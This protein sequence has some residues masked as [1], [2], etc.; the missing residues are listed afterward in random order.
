MFNRNYWFNL[1]NITGP[2][3]NV[4]IANS[5][6]E[7]IEPG[8]PCSTEIEISHYHL[9]RIILLW[10]AGLCTVQLGLEDNCHFNIYNII[11]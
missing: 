9:E 10:P 4:E 2:W 3:G 6:Q 7:G 8:S 1:Q 11:I 5:F